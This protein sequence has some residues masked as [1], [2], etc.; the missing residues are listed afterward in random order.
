M[1][2]IAALALTMAAQ[3]AAAQ[4]TVALLQLA[5]LSLEQL[6]NI[7]VTSVAG[8][9]QSLQEAASSI[10]VISSD[11]IRRSAAT[12]LPEAL[13]LAP[14]LQVAQVSAG[15]WAISARGFNNAIANKLLVLIDGRTVYSTLFSG[16]IW[17]A[18]QVMLEDVE[19]IEVISGPGGTLWGANAVN[20]IIN[21][22]MRPA[23]ATQGP[24]ASVLRSNSGG[25]ESVRW[26]G[27]LG[28]SGHV[29]L[30]G[31]ATD[32]DNTRLESGADLDDASSQ[33]QVGF[34]ADWRFGPSEL[35]LQGDAYRGGS[36]PYSNLS[37][38]LRGGNL[39]VRWTD[40]LADGS[41]YKLQAHYDHAARDEVTVFRNTARTTDLQ[42]TYEPKL[43]TTGRQFLW[44][45]GYRRSEDV[46]LPSEVVLF[47]PQERLLSWAHL[48][49]QHQL[50]LGERWQLTLGA[51]GERNSYTG[52]EFLPNARLAYLHSPHTTTWA[53]A[54]RVVRAPARLDRELFFPGRAPFL[55]AGGAGF[56]SETANVLEIGHRG[57]IESTF[58]YSATLFQQYYKGLRGG[59]PGQVPTVISN[60]IEGASRGVEAWASWQAT[61][62]WRLSAGLL[63]QRKNL[64]FSSGA[65]D[66]TSIPNLGNDPRFQWQLRSSLSLGPRSEFDLMVR[67]VGALPPPVVPRY[68]AV[69]ARLALRVRP[70]FELSLL[71]QNLFDSKHVEFNAAARASQIERRVFIKATWQL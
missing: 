45:A 64:R 42:F 23:V 49:A 50:Q 14:N 7:E 47:R 51:K 63:N 56:E 41:T 10:Y 43:Q 25:R 29:R 46:N 27:R 61:P 69:D 32:R 9:R 35:T 55:V 44:G 31:L 15:R 3:Y 58:S 30:H 57:Q 36:E 60:Q 18:Q 12:S 17:D 70:G 2:C 22:I 11:D 39:L 28:D 54:S 5:D 71:G 66:L 8:R 19:R 20:G 21:V 1:K 59:I 34:R 40:Q 52:L 48:F 26:G 6:S 4:G 37:P 62:D 65:S 13:R 38:R 68:T 24:L 67:Q 53:A 16:V 33:Q